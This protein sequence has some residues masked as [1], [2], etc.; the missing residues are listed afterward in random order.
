MDRIAPFT[1]LRAFEAAARHLSFAAAAD[2]L[3]VTPAALSFQIRS[4]EDH[5]GA[6]VFH[7]RNR[8]VDL[9]E[10]GSA[11]YPGV[12]EG[13]GT[14]ARAWGAAR[15][16]VTASSLTITA[17]PAFTAKWLAPRL[18]TFAQANP[19]LEL[20]FAATLRMLDFARDEIDVAIRF[21]QNKTAG[22]FNEVII[23]EWA[24]PMM[25]PNL[26]EKVKVPSDLLGLPFIH[27]DSLTFLKDAAGWQAWFRAMQMDPPAE[28][29]PR[30]SQADHAVDLALSG[31]GVVLGR[32]SIA[33]RSLTEGRL[34][35]PFAETIRVPS[36]YRLTCP[37]GLET[38]PAVQR[39][40]NW[41][42]A[43]LQTLKTLTETRKF[44]N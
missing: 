17:G 26:A 11:L 42:R 2:E 43:E 15:R 3:N 9:T 39:L 6:P 19:D 31:G 24:T 13:L 33:E 10:L 4:L 44:I 28:H 30:F 20:R 36:E 38:T 27:D 29:G 1:A 12:A 25:H 37:N 23:S 32:G 22:Q 8:A 18:F 40:R 34:V 35:A 7:R 21:G 5:L 14:L 41:I 16:R